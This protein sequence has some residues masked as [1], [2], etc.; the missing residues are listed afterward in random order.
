M[1]QQQEQG[2][3]RLGEREKPAEE[4]QLEPPSQALDPVTGEP[5]PPRKDGLVPSGEP[6]QAD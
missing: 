5:K 6:P 2:L 3:A 4:Q 1:E